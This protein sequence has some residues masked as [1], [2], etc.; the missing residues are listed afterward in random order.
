MGGSGVSGDVLAAVT[1]ASCPIPVVVHRGYGLPGW[2]GASDLVIAVSCS[3]STAETLSAAVEAARRG[4]RLLGVGTANS[5][6]DLHCRSESGAFIPITK[7]LA[8]RASLW[9]LAVPLLVVAAR[10]GLLDLGPD[11]ADLEATAARL[12][13]IAS[14]CRP[15]RESFVNPAKSLAAELIGSLPLIWGSGET[16]PVAALR[17]GCQLAENSKMPAIWGALPEAHHNQ[18]VA[19]EGELGASTADDDL[20]RDRV[21]DPEPFRLHLVLV[22]DDAGDELAARR[23]DASA[24]IAQSRGI[25]VSTLPAEGRSAIE[26]LASLIG[27]I[28]YASVYLGLAQGIDPTPIPPIDELKGRLQDPGASGSD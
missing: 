11:D 12:D 28:D 26:R 21:D 27:L 4:A 18:S 19:L 6:L 3:G 25:S 5:P 8:P 2:V 14:M 24:A 10:A 16:G 23:A 7:Q 9:A 17:A 22:R 20:F 1:S 15:D 13:E